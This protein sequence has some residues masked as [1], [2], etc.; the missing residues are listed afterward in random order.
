MTQLGGLHARRMLLLRLTMAIS[1]TICLWRNAANALALDD[2]RLRHPTVMVLPREADQLFWVV[3][4][5]LFG[6]IGRECIAP[7]AD[8]PFPQ[9][10]ILYGLTSLGLVLQTICF[11]AA[12]A[13]WMVVAFGAMSALW[14]SMFAAYVLVL[15][16]VEPP[17]LFATLSIHKDVGYPC[18]RVSDYLW[19]RVPFTLYASWLGATT[20]ASLTVALATVGVPLDMYIYISC[21]SAL[22]MANVVALL[23]QGD[24]VF[25]SVGAWAFVWYVALLGRL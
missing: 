20:M 8:L 2:V 5:F 24:L 7:C 13:D 18:R 22:L 9:L 23:W 4:F 15:E 12:S 21:F 11:E 3:V 16:N 17:H 25:A 10:E 19:M 1:F 6:F 14:L